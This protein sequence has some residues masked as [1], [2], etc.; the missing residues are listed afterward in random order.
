MERMVDLK[1]QASN[2]TLYTV[3]DA[4]ENALKGF[5]CPKAERTDILMSVE[6]LYTNIASYAYGGQRGDVAVQ[7]DMIG[8]QRCRVTFVDHGI[9][10]NPLER[11]SPDITLSAQKREVGG[12]GIFMVKQMMDSV[13]YRFEN[14]CNILTIEKDI[15]REAKA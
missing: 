9:P 4:I 13:R 2:D 15:A 12:L 5:G 3:R 1:L 8:D 6:E 11:K 7:M 14:G 10:Y